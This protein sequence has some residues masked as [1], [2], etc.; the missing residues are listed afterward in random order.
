MQTNH[1]L[2]M[3]DTELTCCI[4]DLLDFE[5]LMTDRLGS[6]E[7]TNYVFR[8]ND[9]LLKREAAGV[10]EIQKKV[11]AMKHGD[12]TSVEEIVEAVRNATRSAIIE[13]ELPEA[14][15]PLMERRIQKIKRFIESDSA[16]L[17]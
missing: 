2:R 3:L 6:M 15:F 11:R 1:F 5:K 9:A 12:F 16:E 10:T 13:H 4:D 17:V 7:I 14:V 8:E